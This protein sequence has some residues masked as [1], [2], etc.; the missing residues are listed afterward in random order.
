MVK[1]FMQSYLPF[2]SEAAFE[3]DKNIVCLAQTDMPDFPKLIE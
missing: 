3:V 2:A 1:K